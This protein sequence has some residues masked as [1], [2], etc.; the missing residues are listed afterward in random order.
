MRMMRSVEIEKVAVIALGAVPIVALGAADGGFYPRPWGWAT[1]GLA[2]TLIVAACARRTT[3]VSR[4]VL[5]LMGILAAIGIWTAASLSWTRSVGAT[6]FELERL[7]V[8]AA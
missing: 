6:A 2:L 5:L 1:V 7:L 3:D 4:N 8:Y